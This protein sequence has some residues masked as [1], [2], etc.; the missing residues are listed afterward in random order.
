LNETAIRSFVAIDIPDEIKDKLFSSYE[1]CRKEVKASWV[2]PE[3][4]HITLKFLG[5]CSQDL[6]G[7]LGREL[8]SKLKTFGEFYIQVGGFAAFPGVKNAR[9]LWLKAVSESNKLVEICDLVDSVATKVGFPKEKRKPS[10]HITI[11][12]IREPV[13]LDF[14]IFNESGDIHEFKCREVA[15]F[16]STLTRCGSIYEVIST[17][18][19]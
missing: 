5:N 12:R 3:N 16:K 13:T 10:P 7:N 14:S 4:L 19:L 9:V 8:E 17:I 15:I 11:A 18:M 1:K 2:K 6:I